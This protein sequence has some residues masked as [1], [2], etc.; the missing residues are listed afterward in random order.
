MIEE[1]SLSSKIMR[2]RKA[3]AI[4]VLVLIAVLV[5]IGYFLEQDIAAANGP[6]GPGCTCFSG[7]PYVPSPLYNGTG[8][9]N[10]NLANRTAANG[11]IPKYVQVVKSNN[12]LIFHSTNITL[13]VFAYPNFVAG[14]VTNRPIPAY[15]CNAPCPSLTNYAADN[16]SLSNSFT[17]YGLVLPSLVIPH[18][19]TINVTL[20][21]LDPTDHHSFVLSTLPPP[22]P[23]YIMQNMATG[24]EMLA[25]TP[26]LPPINMVTNTASVYSYSVTIQTDASQMWYM[27]MF[28]E[29]AMMGMYGNITLV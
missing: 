4:L 16:M 21:N 5:P 6:S 17:I 20:I 3:I 23:E 25:M 13:L 22:Y 24:G 27:C 28:P 7:N 1:K 10:V 18:G 2:D 14:E 26:L 29:H 15:D 8:Q 11:T 12:T 9:I 19:A